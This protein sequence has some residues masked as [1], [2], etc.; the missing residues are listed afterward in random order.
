MQKSGKVGPARRAYFTI[1]MISLNASPPAA[2]SNSKSTI[3]TLV[4]RA[5]GLPALPAPESSH[6]H[7]RRRF[8]PD[9]NLDDARADAGIMRQ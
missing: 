2:S 3:S 6:Y 5:P 7:L 8:C 4:S 1:L 9:F